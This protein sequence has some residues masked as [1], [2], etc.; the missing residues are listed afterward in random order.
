MKT[1]INPTIDDLEVDSVTKIDR[2][3]SELTITIKELV[4]DDNTNLDDKITVSFVDYPINEFEYNE[5]QEVTINGEFEIVVDNLHVNNGK[6]T[7]FVEIE[8]IGV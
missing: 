6:I 5:G 2:Y 3:T 8:V 1:I 7:T 4:I